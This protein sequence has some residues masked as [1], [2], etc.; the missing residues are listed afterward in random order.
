MLPRLAN[1][2]PVHRQPPQRVKPPPQC[3]PHTPLAFVL[4]IFFF[5]FRSRFTPSHLNP[6]FQQHIESCGPFVCPPPPLTVSHLLDSPPVL[7]LL[8]SLAVKV[9]SILSSLSRPPVA[10]VLPSPPPPPLLPLLPWCILSISCLSLS[11]QATFSMAAT[12]L[13]KR[14]SAAGS[15]WRAAASPGD[16]SSLQPSPPGRA[17]RR[18]VEPPCD[19][20]MSC[21]CSLKCLK[22]L[23]RGTF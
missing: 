1:W 5:H 13:L 22:C 8:G 3:S 19:Q 11:I 20:V 6:N 15:R 10:P 7:F 17:A 2:F 14:A 23:Q 4:L 12:A 21:A 9:H 18:Q 16:D